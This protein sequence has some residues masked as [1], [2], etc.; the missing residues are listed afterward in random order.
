MNNGVNKMRTKLLATIV[1]T[2]SLVAL[3][4]SAF[5]QTAAL[6]QSLTQDDLH[7]TAPSASYARPSGRPLYNQVSPQQFN[8]EG[9]YRN[10]AASVDSAARGA[11]GH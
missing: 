6:P 2:A 7:P 9:D 8:A 10:G 4:A 3:Q 5:A 11:T 1:A